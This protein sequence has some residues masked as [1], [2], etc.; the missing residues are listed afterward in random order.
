MATIMP[1]EKKVRDAL[2]WIIEQKKDKGR[3]EEQEL[4]QEA[5]FKYNLNPKE[6]IYLYHLFRKQEDSD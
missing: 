3:K 2:Q 6:E 1:E 5:C 4:L